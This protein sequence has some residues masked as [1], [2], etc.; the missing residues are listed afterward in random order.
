MNTEPTVAQQLEDRAGDRDRLAAYF[1]QHPGEWL[2]QGPVV[3]AT[4]IREGSLRSRMIECRDVLKMHIEI[5]TTSFEGADGKKHRGLN[6]WR[7]LD[8]V[9]LG[10][11]ASLPTVPL[12]DKNGQQEMFR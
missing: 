5:R 3:K 7:Y 8:Y 2:N 10:R 9:P 11:D 12:V 1:R 6:E 4:G